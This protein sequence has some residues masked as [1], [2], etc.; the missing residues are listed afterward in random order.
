MARDLN[1]RIAGLTIAD[2]L[3]SFDKIV[4]S[5]PASFAPLLKGR[6]IQRVGRIG[7]WIKADLDS[8]A[9]LL[10]HLKMTGQFFLGEWPGSVSSPWPPHARA[11]FLLTGQAED[12][13]LYYR[14]IRKFGRL[15]AFSRDDLRDFLSDLALG[16]DPLELGPGEFHRLV[17]SK[18]GRLKQVLMDQSVVSGLGNIYA[19]ESLFA[20]SLSPVR[21]ASALTPGEAETLLAR[22][23]SILLDAIELRGS[24]VGNY[25]GLDGPGSYQDR[26][27]AYG[28]S[29]QD[30]PRCGNPFARAIIA[31]RSS[32][33]CPVCQK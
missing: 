22:I 17:S 15:R 28:K 6:S 21:P 1:K 4:A 27:K 2:V 30:C 19:D 29:G 14:D 23:K 33:H 16:P 24:T 11:A 3:V 10:A 18:K 5:D 13:T 8:G 26:H 7:K 31:G 9:A 25:Q 12:Q 20:A 32:V